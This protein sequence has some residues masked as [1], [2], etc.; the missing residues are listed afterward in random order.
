M[1]GRLY[2]GD[3]VHPAIQTAEAELTSVADL[4]DDV[5]SSV[6]GNRLRLRTAD[7]AREAEIDRRYLC[8]ARYIGQ[9]C[10]EHY[11]QDR[12]VFDLDRQKNG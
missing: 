1:K 8:S 6:E 11:R 4:D 7:G 2:V 12:G 5:V 3:T 9:S 10:G